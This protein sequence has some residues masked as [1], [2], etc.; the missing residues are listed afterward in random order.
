VPA[1]HEQVREVDRQKGVGLRGRE[2]DRHVVDLA[3]RAQGR[4][5]RGGDAD[6]A[7]VEMRAL[8]SSTFCTFQTTASALKSEP[9][10]NLTPGRS[11]N[12]HLVLSA[13]STFHS[14]ATPGMTPDGSFSFERSHCERLS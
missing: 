4:H 10:W 1:S 13:S 9:S 3:R 8:L 11:R 6:L 12:V 14:V 5:A 7:R 2:L